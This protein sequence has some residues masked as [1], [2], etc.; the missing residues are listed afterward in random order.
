MPKITCQGATLV[1]TLGSAPANLQVTSNTTVKASG[2]RVA[3]IKDHQAMANIPSF[4]AC[5]RSS[6]PPPCMPA[7]RA[8]TTSATTV[9]VQGNPPLNAQSTTTCSHGGS[10][11]VQVPGSKNEHSPS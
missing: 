2:S 3:T 9:K 6:P 7:A 4:G 10:I 1:C 11:R 5:R 8:W